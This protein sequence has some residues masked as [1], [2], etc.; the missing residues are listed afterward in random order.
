M[1][2]AMIEKTIIFF[3][4]FIAQVY[5]KMLKITP[6]FVLIIFLQTETIAQNLQFLNIR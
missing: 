4:I 5:I 1:K 2:Y 3:L 6:A